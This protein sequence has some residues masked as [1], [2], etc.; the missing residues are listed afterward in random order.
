MPNSIS[1]CF[2]NTIRFSHHLPYINPS[3]A[4]PDL[5]VREGDRIVLANMENRRQTAVFLTMGII[6]Q[7]QLVV[8]GW[9]SSSN[10]TQVQCIALC[11]FT[12]KYQR[13]VATIGTALQ[14]GP[15]VDSFLG[16]LLD[17]NMVFGTRPQSTNGLVSTS[18]TAFIILFFL[19]SYRSWAI[20]TL[21]PW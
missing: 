21:A 3:H 8:P 2:R 19:I 14:L 17:G 7:C 6:S 20:Y 9:S 10:A 4:S 12:I 1:R 18:I 11:P 16:P 15:Q 13:A 5:V